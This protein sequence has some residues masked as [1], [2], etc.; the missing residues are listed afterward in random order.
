MCKEHNPAPD[1]QISEE[2]LNVARA[3]FED[4]LE[5]WPYFGWDSREEAWK[6]IS[7][8]LTN[9]YRAMRLVAPQS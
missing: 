4:I 3:E 9:A 7:E 1:V 5:D 2:M 8:A 6:E